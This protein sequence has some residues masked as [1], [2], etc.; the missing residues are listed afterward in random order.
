MTSTRRQRPWRL[1]E[2]GHR[3]ARRWRAQRPLPTATALLLAVHSTT[4]P[5][6][7]ASP[8][9]RPPPSVPRP[10]AASGASSPWRPGAYWP[11][12]PVSAAL[13]LIDIIQAV[14]RPMNDGRLYLVCACATPPGLV[15]CVALRPRRG[16]SS[17]ARHPTWSVGNRTN[18][19]YIRRTTL[20]A[21][22]RTSTAKKKT[23]HTSRHRRRRHEHRVGSPL[24]RHSLVL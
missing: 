18:L 6:R 22:L 1:T 24:G 13:P 15:G 3:P 9:T 11:F 17:S 12:P 19:C 2:V 7:R 4:M 14:R 8:T 10:S 20:R 23:A 5:L 21:R 16:P